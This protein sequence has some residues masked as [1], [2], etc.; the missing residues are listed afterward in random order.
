MLTDWVLIRRAAGE[1]NDRFAGARVEDAGL[2]PDGRVALVLRRRDGA[3]AVAFDVFG[4]PPLVTV[5]PADLAIGAEPGFVRK[6]AT[7]LRGMVVGAVA[8]RT[9]DRLLRFDLRTRSRFGVGDALELY[10]ELTPRFGNLVL[11]KRGSIVAAAKEFSLAQNPARA[12]ETGMAYVLPPLPNGVRPARVPSAVP[13][14]ASVLEAFAGYREQRVRSNALEGVERRRNALL[15]RLTDRRRKLEGE[16]QSL[17]AK[18]REVASA[19]ALREEGEHIYASL[20]ELDEAARTEAKERAVKLFARYKKL[21]ASLPHVETR[22]AAIA[23]AVEAVDALRW[24][25]ERA[26]D[27]DIE[28]VEHATAALEPHHAQAVPARVRKRKRAPLEFRTASGSRIV[29]GRSPTENADVTFRVARPDDLWFHAQGIP[30]AHVVLARDD[31]TPAPPEDIEAAAALAAFH[32]KAR[33]ST[34]VP[35]D[36]TQRKHVRK[37]QKAPPGLVWYTHPTTVLAEPGDA[38]ES[39]G[40]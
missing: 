12:V 27:Q 32:S 5:E 7:T 33:S 28:D 1:L 11:V 14:D 6:L 36:Y 38:L 37:Q 19:S 40:A 17:Q 3:A 16:L 39:P 30:G 31:R 24:E 34:K 21:H 26:S 29:V 22:Q 10:V 13:E 4:T 23:S 9:G 8:S 35:V 20:H 18:R 25:A 2:L 15:R